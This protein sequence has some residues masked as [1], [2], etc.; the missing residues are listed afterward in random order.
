M[1]ICID[2]M[3]IRIHEIWWMR[4]WIQ[5]GFRT[6]KSP[7]RFQTIFQ[8]VKKKNI[9]KSAPILPIFLGLDLKTIISH[10]KKPPKMS[11]L[12]SAFPFIYTSGSGI[13]FGLRIRIH[14]PKWMR[15]RI[16]IAVKKSKGLSKFEIAIFK[17][18]IFVL[19]NLILTNLWSIL[20]F[21][22]LGI[23]HKK[24]NNY[25]KAFNVAF[26]NFYMFSRLLS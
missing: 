22:H 14:G 5:T 4:I 17:V 21:V 6:I 20:L 15:I 24:T 11:W 7:K 23:L 2:S 8:N 16:H 18:I 10:E 19:I 25:F 12:N 9:Y 3:R 1:W 26:H 13:E